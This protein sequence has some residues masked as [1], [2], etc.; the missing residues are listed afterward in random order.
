M[1]GCC[2]SESRQFSQDNVHAGEIFGDSLA[3]IF[4]DSNL[5]FTLPYDASCVSAATVVRARHAYEED[6]LSIAISNTT[7]FFSMALVIT[8]HARNEPETS[9]LPCS[10]SYQVR[11]VSNVFT[12]AAESR[13]V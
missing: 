8:F 12:A 6:S 11:G 4:I 3:S 13:A 10:F 5:F 2:Y 7:F 1:G 9:S